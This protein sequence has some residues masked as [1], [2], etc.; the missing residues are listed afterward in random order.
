MLRSVFLCICD[1]LIRL[2]LYSCGGYDDSSRSFSY[3]VCEGQS[4]MDCKLCCMETTLN[5]HDKES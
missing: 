2:D 4:R 1:G 5:I 3:L